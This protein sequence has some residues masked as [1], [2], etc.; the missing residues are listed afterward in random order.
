MANWP[1]VAGV[2]AE[3]KQAA[4]SSEELVTACRD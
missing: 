3:K 1:V 2:A 4:T